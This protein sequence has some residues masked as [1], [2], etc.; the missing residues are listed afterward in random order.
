LNDTGSG[1]VYSTFL[2]GSGADYGY[3]VALDSLQNAYVTGQTTSS[4]FLT[5]NP[6]QPVLSGN[7]DAFVLKVNSAGD[8]LLYSSYL[9]G[10][11]AESGYAIAVDSGG[12]FYVTGTT[13]STDFPTANAFQSSVGS[14]FTTDA[15]VTKFNSGGALSYSTYLGG[16]LA[17]TGYGIAVDASGNAYVTGQ[18]ASTNFP[19]A[20]AIQATSGGFS[21]DAFVTKLN[22]AGSGLVY[23]TYLGGSST[24]GGRGIAVDSAN[25][26]YIIGF[27]SSADFPIVIGAL[28]TKSPFFTSSN[29][30]SSWRNDNYGLKSDTVTALAL[31]PSQPTTIYAGTRGG[32]YKSINNGRTWNPINSGLVRPSISAIVIDPLTPVT[33]YLAVGFTDPGNSA[34]VYKSVDGGNTWNLTGLGTGILALAIDPVTP[35]TLY[36]SSGSGVFKTINGG[37]NWNPVGQPLFQIQT[38]AVDPA[39]PTTVYAGANSSPGGVFKTI[40]GGATWQAINNGLTG[41]FVLRLA[42]DPTTPSTVYAG[43]NGGLCKSVNGGST[44]TSITTGLTSTYFNAFAFDPISSSTIYAGSGAFSGGIFKSSN[45]GSNWTPITNDLRY[46]AI[47]SIVVNPITPSTIH[48]GTSIFPPDEDAF[49][50]KLSP[51]G[52]SFLYSTFLGGQVSDSS[53]PNEQGNAI[54]LDSNGNTYVAGLSRA[55]DFPV[56]PDSYQPFNRGFT[57]A[58]I[59]K[60][61][62]SYVISGQVLDGSNAPVSGA[63]VTLND[64]SSLSSVITGIDG[65]YQFVNLPQGGNFTVSAAK[66]HFT[67]SPTSQTFNNLNGDQIVNFIATA[68]NAA[69]YTIAGQIKE[70]GSPLSGVTVTLSG[71]QSGTR[72][73]DSAGNYSFTL[74]EAGNYTVTPTKFGFTFAPASQTFNNL[75][76]NQTADF[77]ATRQSFVV[78]NANDH[79]T[80]SLRQ[81]DS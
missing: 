34:G 5:A 11:S 10:S 77:S 24:D 58:F 65:S 72:T 12:N 22:N 42:I 2:G 47:S 59:A 29:G 53:S 55:P 17:E 6:F 3:G 37:A 60:L 78:T 76:A 73:T 61:T 39:T 50:T 81:G 13:S 56:T 18:T 51:S 74:L 75:S 45:G 63:E 30:G 80:G 19:T 70:N 32:V 36:A 26:A 28:K 54:A 14:T 66:P 44:W 1:L 23:S 68:T 31:D 48:I 7:S 21:G 57:D 9:G 16:T 67:M 15:F 40:D 41:S 43:L 4:D 46:S 38:I 25:N 52:T 27:T 69:F 33:V 8:S 64:G 20:N 79:G 49:V 71:S 62:M 35:A